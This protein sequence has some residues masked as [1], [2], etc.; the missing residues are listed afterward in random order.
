MNLRSYSTFACAIVIECI[1]FDPFVAVVAHAAD[2]PAKGAVAEPPAAAA[3]PARAAIAAELHRLFQERH[4]WQKREFPEYAMS[5]GDYSNAARLSDGS[6]AAIERRHAETQSYLK[7]LQALER[8]GL[9]AED[10]LN[11]DLFAHLLK[12]DIDGH[13]FRMWLAPL[14]ARHGPHQEIPQMHERVRFE[15]AQDYIDYFAR[16]EQTPRLIDDTI[17]LLRRGVQEGRTPPQIVLTGVPRQFAALLDGGGLEALATPLQDIRGVPEMKDRTALRER[18]DQ[19]T[20]PAVKAAVLKFAEFVG[21]EYIP[22]CRTTLGARDL[23][24]GLAFYAH[25]LRVMTTTDL[26]AARIHELGLAEVQRIRAEMLAVI[27]KSD[28]Y[29]DSDKNRR[30]KDP[31]LFENFLKFLRTDPRFYHKSEDDLLREY[32]DICKRIDAELPK[33]FRRLPRLSYGVR[34]IPDF[35]AP[36]QTTAYYQRGDIRNAEPGYFYANAYALDQRPRY[37]MMALAIHE[38][39]PGHH[40]QVAIAQE[41]EHVPEFRKDMWITA[42]GEGWALY[43]ERLGLEVGLYETPYDLFGRLT[44]EMWRACRLVVD[45]GIHTLGWSRDRALQFM[46]ENSALSEL[47]ITAEVDRYISWPGQATG[48]KIG[49]LKIRELRRRAEERL[50]SA[51]DKRDFHDELLSAGCIPLTI[52]ETRINAWIERQLS[53]RAAPPTVAP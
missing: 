44:Y 8:A 24:D 11:Y 34:K 12:E 10:Q 17:D 52:L 27:R 28:F 49:E 29:L 40:F 47:N 42:F 15:S 9:S 30:L 16:L 6:Y 31:E 7:R 36:T 53:A 33:L 26:T 3:N 22:A 51:F 13:A 48:Y 45:T 21:R 35:M 20:F 23:P 2:G 4:D 1:V 19:T 46:R 38:A 37:E 25:Q 14:G 18:F 39:V 50:G 41:L 5:C 43:S 32:R